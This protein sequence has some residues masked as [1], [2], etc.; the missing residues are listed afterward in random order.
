MPVYYE[1]CDNPESLISSELL[2][3][4]NYG[5]V[6]LSSVK[7]QITDKLSKPFNDCIEDE[8]LKNPLFQE[9]LTK[10]SRYR[11]TTCHQLCQLHHYEEVCQCSLSY[12]LGM[13]GNDTCDPEC[14][15]EQRD[16]FQPMDSCD[17]CPLECD[18][19]SFETN[20]DNFNLSVLND[21]DL[22]EIANYS[23]DSL[24]YFQLNF[25]KFS[26]KS[27]VEVPK[28]TL[29]DF[30]GNLGGLFGNINIGFT[31]ILCKVNIIY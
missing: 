11:Q 29:T 14:V 30:I 5:T 8:N 18:T 28:M 1:V 7:K 27:F 2:T 19:V 12:Q 31:L 17:S 23:H 20:V 13:N 25:D 16:L 6:T 4:A 21:L 22:R 3:I 9:T 26:Y 15:L 10:S 24:V